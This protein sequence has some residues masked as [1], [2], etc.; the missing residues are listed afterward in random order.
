MQLAL[1]LSLPIS[2]SFIRPP[3]SS[4][5]K[6]LDR[7]GGRWSRRIPKGIRVAILETTLETF[8]QKRVALASRT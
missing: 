8:W 5:P 4:S 2:I 3:T 6:S 7:A 1:D